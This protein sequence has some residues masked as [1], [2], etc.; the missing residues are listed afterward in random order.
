MIGGLEH[1]RMTE[2]A[3]TKTESG[4]GTSQSGHAM[5]VLGP[6]VIGAILLTGCARWEGSETMAQAGAELNEVLPTVSEQDT[7]QSI[8]ENATF[9]EVFFAIW[10]E[11]AP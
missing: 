4:R 1:E 9:R 8:A 5:H 3:K 7:M 11:Y 2:N 10:P 6:L